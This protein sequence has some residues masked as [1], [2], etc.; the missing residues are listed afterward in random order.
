MK[1]GRIV[2]TRRGGP[3]TLQYIEEE[4]PEPGPGQ[5]RVKVLATG[6]SYADVLMRHGLYP[7]TP[8]PPFTPGYDI[9]GVVDKMGEGTSKFAVGQPVGALI[10]RGGYS[11]HTIVPEEY[12]VPVPEG[13]DPSEAVS[14][15]LNYGTAYQ[16]LH[17]VCRVAA[18][19]KIL[20]H[21]AAGGVG[22]ALL[23]L[24][25]LAQL[26]MYG[27]ASKSKHA[28]VVSE[29][30]IAID[31]RSED[32]VL[33][34]REL[35]GDGVD[36]VFDPIGGWNWW[37]SYRVLRKRGILVCYGASA[38]VTNGKMSAAG[39]FLLMGILRVIPDGRKSAW[40]NVTNLRKQHPDWFREDLSIL[41]DLLAQKKIR[42]VIGARL[43]LRDAVK[44][45]EML[46]RAEVAGKIVLLCQE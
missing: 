39:G 5:V 16:M 29:G 40:F 31:Y 33:R 44:A 35:T 41:Y 24:G 45:N 38:A 8:P 26:K 32:F 2:V 11:R 20:I 19:R 6:V 17:R 7:G 25:A 4:I 28:A 10:V 46:E 43:A 15:I 21:G 1:N 14:L 18:G 13:L 22:T 30:G 34:I 36:Y 12:L 9:V 42:P 37:R 27:T 23:Q 3:E